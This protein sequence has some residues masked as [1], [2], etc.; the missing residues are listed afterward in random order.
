M[1]ARV[2]GGVAAVALGAT[3]CSGGT[4]HKATPPQS[5]AT[6]PE[7]V[8]LPAPPAPLA[9]P[10][11]PVAERATALARAT[12]PGKRA[13][14]GWLAA[15]DALGVPVVDAH[16]K[17]VG[18]TPSDALAAPYW[19]VWYAGGGTTKRGNLLLTDF[20]RM[21]VLPSSI[22]AS[23]AATA[24]VAD[25]R[26]DAVS[27]RSNDQ[28]F[29]HFI[30]DKAMQTSV[31][32]DPLAATTK[33]SQVA[34]D[35]ATAVLLGYEFARGAIAT[36]AS[37][38]AK[39]GAPASTVKPAA[40]VFG[41]IGPAVLTAMRMQEGGGVT[42]CSTIFGNSKDLTKIINTII[43]NAAQGAS[44]PGTDIKVP[45][46]LEQAQRAAG[47]NDDAVK[48]SKT[49]AKNIGLLMSVLDL[50]L[51]VE[52]LQVLAPMDPEPLVRTHDTSNGKSATITFEISTDP[53]HTL[54]DDLGPGVSSTD[55]LA[56]A[57]QMIA[58]TLGVSLKL[59]HAQK[60]KGVEVELTPKSGFGQWVLFD[61]SDLKY[62]TNANGAFTVPVIGKAQ[63]HTIPDTAKPFQRE[64]VIGVEAQTQ[65]TDL[66]SIISTFI[67]GFKFG[68]GPSGGGG[69]KGMLDVLKTVHWDLG[70]LVFN[71]KDWFAGWHV[72]GDFASYHFTGEVCDLERPFQLQA[73]SAQAGVQGTFTISPAAGATAHG[74]TYS[75]SGTGGVFP[76][77]PGQA[78]V[79]ATGSIDL[80]KPPA[81]DPVA[82]G[83][84]RLDPGN[85]LV[86]APV[87][88]SLPF[89][90]GG[91]HLGPTGEVLSLTPDPTVCQ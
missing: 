24:L 13:I 33:A 85:W 50:L 11:G 14:A 29:A 59:P 78:A 66:S 35:P 69:L 31:G 62:T 79:T 4:S 74:G 52:S 40:A 16:G 20:V 87:V 77:S 82:L 67:D 2:I 54:G 10:G 19:Q 88:G 43:Q 91:H 58:S 7:T 41:R 51:Q 42:D 37:S 81:D 36:L 27:S 65:A 39:G 83:E 55:W 68:S 57:S 64:F 25:L 80:K 49:A 44:I 34:I 45:G 61:T 26:A 86:H 70:D 76:G 46:L 48:S 38:A 17:T 9:I 60:L 6:P 8:V 15:Y 73:K 53:A 84:L 30:A 71:E 63:S 3:G 1:A 89:G 56:C 12:A 22:D 28:L 32:V 72:D 21:L 5:T 23:S 47:W 75:F 90:P 18:R